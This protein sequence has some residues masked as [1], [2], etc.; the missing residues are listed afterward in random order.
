MGEEKPLGEVLNWDD[1]NIYQ[2]QV[3]VTKKDVGETIGYIIGAGLV[4]PA[5]VYV[6]LW[7]VSWV[8][9]SVA[10]GLAYAGF[11][12]FLV[13]YA[14][15]LR[16]LFSGNARNRLQSEWNGAACAVFCIGFII[17]ILASPNSVVGAD[18][19][20][21]D[22]RP[23]LGGWLLYLLDNTLTVILLD[24]PDVLLK[25]KL[26]DITPN[27][28]VSRA[29]VILFRFLVTAGLIQVAFL[30]IRQI[31]EDRPFYGT[32]RE[33]FWRCEHLPSP[34]QTRVTMQA[35][36]D[37]NVVHPSFMANQFLDAFRAKDAE[38][39]A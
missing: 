21:P 1:E 7:G 24:V 29:T 5:V 12:L 4:C 14:N 34:E 26:S 11:V 17:Y 30:T 2:W 31:L 13:V 38:T 18:F 39:S 35:R 20:L 25:W 23:E 16:L 6:V 8:S 22:P 36:I 10:S 37:V 19:H 32:V 28:W 27:G 9:A 33:L 15:E 3:L